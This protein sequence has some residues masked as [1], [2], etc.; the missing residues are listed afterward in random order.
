MKFSFETQTNLTP[1]TIWPFYEIVEK[2]YSWEDDLEV[3][4]LDGKFK[5]GSTGEMTLK[6][7]PPMTFELIEVIQNEC[8]C[9]KTVIPNLGEILF[10]HELIVNKEKTTVRH[11]VEFI[12]YND[13]D[14]KEDVEFVSQIF[15]DVPQSIFS[16]IEAAE[17]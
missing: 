17:Q 5:K 4:S 16:L 3:I 8:F 14:K 6:N 7:Q 15:S 11:S 1:E 2:W 9:D 10:N 12:R 13:S